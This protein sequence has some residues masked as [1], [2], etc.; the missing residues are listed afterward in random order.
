[1][2]KQLEQQRNQKNKVNSTI[3]TRID[4]AIAIPIKA[5]T[6]TDVTNSKSCSKEK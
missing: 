5:T 2:S 6:K 1:M 4:K 3:P